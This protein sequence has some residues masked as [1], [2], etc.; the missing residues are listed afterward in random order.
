MYLH[1]ALQPV[2][3]KRQQHYYMTH[4]TNHIATEMAERGIATFLA[5]KKSRHRDVNGPV[6]VGSDQ[7]CAITRR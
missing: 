5:G 1:M 4:I 6:A 2:V 3:G 7:S